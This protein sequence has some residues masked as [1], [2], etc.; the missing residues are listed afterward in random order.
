M[1]AKKTLLM[2]TA[3]AGLMLATEAPVQAKEKTANVMCYGVNACKGK[4][5]CGGKVDACSGKN[6]CKAVMSCAGHNSC[7]GKGLIKMTKKDCLA[8]KGKVA[9]ETMM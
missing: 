1:S 9:T 3:L 6:G 2:G 5:A 8:K 7:K 4:G